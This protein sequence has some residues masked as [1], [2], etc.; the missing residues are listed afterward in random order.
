MAQPE[1]LADASTDS[2]ATLFEKGGDSRW[3]NHDLLS[4]L[5]RVVMDN[6]GARGL[7][8]RKADEAWQRMREV[9]SRRGNEVALLL[10]RYESKARM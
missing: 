4:L 2:Y 8:P 3:M 10:M 1:L 5:T 9:Y 6:V 7:S